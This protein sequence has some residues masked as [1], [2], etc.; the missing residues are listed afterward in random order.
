MVSGKF[1]GQEVVLGS[2]GFK[3]LPTGSR[4][5]FHGYTTYLGYDLDACVPCVAIIG[6][7]R[8][9]GRNV[10][11]EGIRDHD[12][13]YEFDALIAELAGDA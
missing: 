3:S 5:Y 13:V 8:I 11:F 2:S 4:L 6:R 7:L 10:A 9:G 1:Y 12:P